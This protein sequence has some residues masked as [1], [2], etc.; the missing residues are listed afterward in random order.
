LAQEQ[1]GLDRELKEKQDQIMDIELTLEDLKALTTMLS[2]K[3]KRLEDQVKD[4]EIKIKE[5]EALKQS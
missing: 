4:I 2:E 3:I 1:R 5:L